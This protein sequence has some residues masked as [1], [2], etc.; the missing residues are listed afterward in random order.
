MTNKPFKPGAKETKSLST[1]SQRHEIRQRFESF[2]AANSTDVAYYRRVVREA[3]ARAIDMLL[4]KDMQRHEAEMRVVDKQMPMAKE[5]YDAQDADV[6]ARID[7]RLKHVQP[8]YRDKAFVDS[9]MREIDR[10]SRRILDSP[11]PSQETEE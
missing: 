6:Q 7:S 1:T 10:E 2:K 9:V 4:Y 3:P 5:F 11:K 8:Y